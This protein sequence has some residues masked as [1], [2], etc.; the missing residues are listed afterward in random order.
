MAS[1]LPYQPLPLKVPAGHTLLRQGD[2]GTTVWKV[3]SGAFVE[4]VHD[5]DGRSA[6]VD[7]AGPGQCIGCVPDTPA[8][9]EGKRLARE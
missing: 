7:I 5:A 6:V 3:V 1:R 2:L 8:P 4:R 9:W